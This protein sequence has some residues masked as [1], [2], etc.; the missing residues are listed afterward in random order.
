MAERPT[1]GGSL[2]RAKIR[3]DHSLEFDAAILD[4]HDRISSILREG[5]LDR[6]AWAVLER[7]L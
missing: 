1:R 5:D 6:F 2:K 3:P 7:H 4:G